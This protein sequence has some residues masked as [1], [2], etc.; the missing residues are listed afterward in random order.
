[1]ADTIRRFDSGLF[2]TIEDV[3]SVDAGIFARKAA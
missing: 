3:R 2:F 1:L